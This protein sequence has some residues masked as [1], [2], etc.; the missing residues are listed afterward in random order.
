MDFSGVLWNKQL[1]IMWLVIFQGGLSL[2]KMLRKKIP[3][4]LCQGNGRE[5]QLDPKLDSWVLI[6]VMTKFMVRL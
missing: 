4:E 1:Q 5:L 3:Q 2:T 6:P